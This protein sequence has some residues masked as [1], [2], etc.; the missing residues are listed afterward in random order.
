MTGDT[1]DSKVGEGTKPSPAH[2]HSIS[3][4]PMLKAIL[5]DLDDTLIDW[6][7]F[8]GD[9]AS[10][11]I[12][13]LQRVY[14]YICAEICPLDDFAG[15]VEAF[16]TGTRDGWMNGRTTLIAPN[17]GKIL[18][19]AAE[20][21][22]VPTGV[23]DIR[24]SLEVY[25]WGAVPGTTLFPEVP[26]MLERLRAAGLR[27]AIV[28]NAFQPMWVRDAEMLEHSLLEWFP[29]CRLSAAD[30]GYLKPHPAIFQ[31]ALDCLGVS[32]DE[33]VFV[34]DNPVA[35]IAGA[36]GAGMQAV[37]RVTGSTQPLLSGLIVPD[38]AI[39]SLTELPEVLDRLYPGWRDHAAAR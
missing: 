10:F 16:R 5:F 1:I 37:L 26:E 35:D 9:W 23:L 7:G 8:H 39:N 11:E 13:F 3:K 14:D 12:Q 6:S 18:V 24:R 27:F 31:K 33:A 32:A 15:F 4:P 28:T 25:G 36:Q 21:A 22:G 2:D 30:V 19:A 17:M 38:G 34:G 29:E 20:A